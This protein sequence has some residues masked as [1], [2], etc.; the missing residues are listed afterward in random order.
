VKLTV[1]ENIYHKNQS[2]ADEIIEDVITSTLF[3]LNK[4]NKIIKT[5]P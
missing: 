1:F 5:A 4:K 3:T 2:S